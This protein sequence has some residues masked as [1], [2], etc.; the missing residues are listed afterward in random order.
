MFAR[1]DGGFG[2]EILARGAPPNNLAGSGWEGQ[3]AG[4]V[5]LV[6]CK[7]VDEAVE[8]QPI[9]AVL[10]KWN[11]FFFFLCFLLLSPNPQ[12]SRR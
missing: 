11:A 8:I 10:S 12:S 6:L 7:M 5:Y 1:S 4:S 9:L 3:A 2:E